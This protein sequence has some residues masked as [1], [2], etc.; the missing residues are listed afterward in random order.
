MTHQCYA[1]YKA[2][3]FLLLFLVVIVS[4][5]AFGQGSE[6]KAAHARLMVLPVD[7]Q[8]LVALKGESS[9]LTSIDDSVWLL[10]SFVSR[11]PDR[12][13]CKALLKE[14]ASLLE[15]IGRYAEAADSWE[16][17]ARC[18]SG[19][20]DAS[21]LL[22]AAA[23][24]LLAGDVDAAS[25]M[26][27]AVA[28]SSPDRTSEKLALLVLGWVELARGN[29]TKALSVAR[30]GIADP[31][32]RVALSAL[33]LARAASEGAE[34]AQ[35]DKGIQQYATRPELG[36]AMPL[37]LI[38]GSTSS[39]AVIEDIPKPESKSPVVSSVY[40]QVGAFRDEENAKAVAAKISAL[41]LTAVVKPRG[42]GELIVVL[43]EPGADAGRTV[44]TLK[45]AG[46][47]AWLVDGP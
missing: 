32:Q 13:Q 45:D 29:K 4:M 47:E 23:C 40:Y 31:E 3:L 38:T 27:T 11:I 19:I 5:T 36:S 9:R 15:L 28:F 22:S 10:G 21:C 46:Y 30:D 24:R 12:L 2:S 35:Y 18:V 26:A 1:P 39:G 42:T 43:V 8:L 33:M 7:A 20:A 6:A 14:H 37:L 16:A 41:G 17:A 44:L 25:G 34:L